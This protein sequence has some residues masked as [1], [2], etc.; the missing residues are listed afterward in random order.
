MLCLAAAGAQLGLAHR[1]RTG[2]AHRVR[3]APGVRAR[4]V[5]RVRAR[6]ARA[7]R[8][9][10]H[11]SF[12]VRVGHCVG[13]A[14]ESA[15]H[16]RSLHSRKVITKSR[17]Q[18]V[19]GTCFPRERPWGS[20]PAGEQ[21][22]LMGQILICPGSAASLHVSRNERVGATGMGIGARE[23]AGAAPVKYNQ[24][25]TCQRTRCASRHSYQRCCSLA[26]LEGKRAECPAAGLEVCGFCSGR[27]CR[28]SSFRGATACSSWNAAAASQHRGWRRRMVRCSLYVITL[29]LGFDHC[30]NTWSG[31]GRR[32][33]LPSPVVTAGPLR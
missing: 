28:A 4:R 22:A 8:V 33:Q 19:R 27:G 32:P 31:P 29:V 13:H 14:P 30:L 15:E 24:C 21:S 10:A 2:C 18:A 9:V 1:V 25:S 12:S 5:H 3:A 11:P 23:K 20:C 6:G 16:A 17:C 26:A 7:R